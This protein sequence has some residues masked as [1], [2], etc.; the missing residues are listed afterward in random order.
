MAQANAKKAKP[1]HK[2][3]VHSND[4]E[5]E[6][7]QI[8][9]SVNGNNVVIKT[10]EEVEIS[11]GIYHVLKNAQETRHVPEVKDGEPTGK[12]KEVQRPRYIL[13]TV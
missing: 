11:N 9:A 13:E 5:N 10:G 7:P 1:T 8:F 6:E 12:S 3:I 2:V 4:R